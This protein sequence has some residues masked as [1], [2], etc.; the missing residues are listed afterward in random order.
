MKKRKLVYCLMAFIC[1]CFTVCENNV[2]KKW[3]EEPMTE[4]IIN[5]ALPVI[6]AHPQSAFYAIGSTA[7]AL[8]IEASVSDNGILSYQWYSNTM[9]D[10]SGGI[11]ISGATGTN[12]TPPTNKKGVIYYYVVV[13]NTIFDN[14]DEIKAIATS[15]SLA[16]EIGIDVRA[17]TISG[18]S[19]Q[20][21]VYDRTTK[22]VVI[23]IP[24]IKGVLNGDDVTLI[25]GTI[26]FADANAGNKKGFTFSGWSLGGANAAGYML[27]IPHLTADITKADPV[28][29]WPSGLSGFAGQTLSQITLPGNG[30]S[31]PSGTFSWTKPADIISNNK[32]Q[33]HKM[34]FTPNDALNYNTLASDVKITI[35]SLV[36]MISIP[37]GTFKMG[38]PSDEPDR[39]SNELQHTVTLRA[40]NMS[41]YP[42]T[43]ELYQAVMGNNPSNFKTPLAGEAGTPGRLPVEQVSWYDALVFCNKLSI[44]EGLNP[45]YQINKKTN[46][47]DWGAVPTNQ[48]QTWNLVEVV[49]GS[50]G[51]R[52]P[53]EAQWE[54]ACRAGT[55][56]AF[57]TGTSFTDSTGWYSGNSGNKTHEIGLKQA[58]A[59]GLYDMHGNV[60]EWCW[61]WY[62]IDYMSVT[63]TDP[64]GP[65]TGVTR[66]RRGGGW[67]N[68]AGFMRSAW[69]D[70]DYPYMRKDKT[71]I[72]LVLP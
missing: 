4:D 27:I 60:M 48:N 68:S 16:A 2:M 55:T 69:R 3:W 54:Y 38:S 47:A 40:F 20:N 43:Q 62:Y 35:A 59:W 32:I 7:Q 53:T 12:Y 31:T 33:S 39:F 23:G 44:M 28:V 64:A 71:G 26:A 24:E 67:S 36:K 37:A 57:N 34:I 11:I 29:I 18:L 1:T 50:N 49:P 41:E 5:I 58:N 56:T 52:L 46:P 13:T 10:N 8:T 30:N 63:V 6:N 9:N 65:Q 70:S 42:V 51:Y 25:Q 21:K 66:I 61:D 72:R 14:N 15:V 45:A 22:T 19:V 17:V